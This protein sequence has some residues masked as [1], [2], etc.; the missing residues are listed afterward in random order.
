[1]NFRAVSSFAARD[2][3]IWWDTTLSS[4]GRIA[5]LVLL[6]VLS[7]AIGMPLQAQTI[8]LP[9]ASESSSNELQ[10]PVDASDIPQDWLRQIESAELEPD[11][12]STR[13]KQVE[14]QVEE[15]LE[16][17]DGD[18]R[19][20]AEVALGTLRNNVA[21]LLLVVQ[22][23]TD[24]NPV[25]IPVQE[26]YSLDEYLVL[27]ATWRGVNALEESQKVSLEQVR[28]QYA[29]QQTRNDLA[30]EAYRAADRKSHQLVIAGLNRMS[31]GV[32]LLTYN[33]TRKRIETSLAGLERSRIDL[34]EQLAYARKH[35][36]VEPDAVSGFKKSVNEEAIERMVADR[37]VLQ[38]QLLTA[39]SEAKGN[40]GFALLKIKMQLIRASAQ[41]SLLR[42]TQALDTEKYHWNMLRA[43]FL[44]SYPDVKE[45]TLGAKELSRSTAEL[46]ETWAKA[47]QAALV[48]PAP[49]SNQEQE[50]SAFNE[51][52]SAARESLAVISNINET[53]DDLGQL[54]LLLDD[55]LLV[56]GLGDSATRF[57]RIAENARLVTEKVSGF[58]LVYIG[59]T[60]VT[61][62]S[63][64]KFFAI[65]IIGFLLS[66]LIQR[67][68]RH[69]QHRQLRF[70]DSSSIYTLGRILHYLIITVAV[71]AGFAALGLDIR[72]LALIAGALSVGIGFGLQ[73][74]VNN[75]LS[76]LILLT[77]GSLRVGDFVELD[78]GVTGVVR[79]IKTRYTRINTND[80]LD[81]VVPNSELVSYRLTNWTLRERVV[82]LRIPF[83]VAYDSDKDRVVKAGNEAAADV[84]FTIKDQN[85]RAPRV[86]LTGFGESS[87]DFELRVWVQHEGVHYPGRV[88]AAYRWALESRLRENG[89][90]IPY[91]QRDLHIQ[92]GL[93]KSEQVDDRA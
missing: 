71:L 55:Q 64:F 83:S 88:K 74:I 9:T 35:L 43:G 63:V 53:S 28:Q 37:N 42:L 49:T 8:R 92:D 11:L 2:L 78:S 59:D 58:R 69:V 18:S 51:A 52:Q 5:N 41:E 29:A 12:V 23:T 6:V 48:T 4:W 10:Q 76:G 79:E 80:N 14:E 25:A 65:I 50:Y 27:R 24:P 77:E 54:W 46:A 89:I 56:H 40:G 87:L 70:R 47:S 44:E 13:F 72:S 82:R 7:C 36:E 86:L 90:T 15:H 66:W 67:F 34:A 75:F 19:T 81:V 68:L 33:E 31:A 1:L 60:P 21:S 17:M 16:A 20:Q 3:L 45:A 26:S 85:N 91:P 57:A 38:N 84:S 32:L 39:I 73:S 62:G 22:Q 61:I 30:V 93:P